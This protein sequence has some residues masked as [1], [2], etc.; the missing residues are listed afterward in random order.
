MKASSGKKF[1]PMIEQPVNAGTRSMLDCLETSK[2][3]SKKLFTA[4]KEISNLSDIEI[5]SILDISHAKFRTYKSFKKILSWRLT[6]HA[7]ALYVLFR[8]G[9]MVFGTDKEFT[10]WLNQQNFYFDGN[11][12]IKYLQIISGI[13]FLDDRLTAMEFGD[14]V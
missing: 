12:P 13:E 14:N 3:E 5:S 4:L 7:I 6:E 11:A 1:V 10:K 8:Q 2:N 9:K